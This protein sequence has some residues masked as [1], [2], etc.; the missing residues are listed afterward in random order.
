MAAARDSLTLRVYGATHGSHSHEHHQML[1]GLEGVLDLEVEGRGQRIGAG[2]ALLVP[3]G[4]RHDFESVAGSR[5]LVLDS[6]SPLWARCG[7]RPQR[8]QQVTALAN[9][10][11]DAIRQPLAVAYA[12]FLLLDAWRSP[13]PLQR[14]RRAIDWPALTAWVHS[15]IDQ[16]VGVSELASRVH[17]SASQFALRCHEAQGMGPLDWLRLQRLTRARQLRD[18]GVPVHEVARRTGYRSPSALTAALRK[19]GL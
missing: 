2:D 4:E 12:P 5:C 1:V 9:Y 19:A 18:D 11:A 16:H 3:A 8:P 13:G 14:A 17:L 7:V 10:L 15:R 6:A